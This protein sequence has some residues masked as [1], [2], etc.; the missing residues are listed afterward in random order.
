MTS[1]EIILQVDEHAN[2]I[3]QVERSLAHGNPQFIHIHT[4][5]MIFNDKN[6]LL[7]QQRSSQKVTHAGFWT[8]GAGGHVEANET[9]LSNIHKEL[10]EELGFDTKLVFV[11]KELCRDE[12]ESRFVFYYLAKYTSETI[13]FDPKEVDAIKFVDQEAFNVMK[14]NVTPRAYLFAKRFWDGEFD[15]LKQQF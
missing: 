14:D 10:M 2:P 6:Q 7:F 3:G 9:P 4:A 8:S 11:E 12:Y 1:S 13:K 15:A 5:C